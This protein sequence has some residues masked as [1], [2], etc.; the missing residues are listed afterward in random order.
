MERLR[1]ENEEM[2]EILLKSKN[3]FFPSVVLVHSLISDESQAKNRIDSR[4]LDL[5][6]LTEAVAERN[7]SL[8]NL[9]EKLEGEIQVL[10]D[11]IESLK[12]EV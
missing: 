4:T 10:E 12:V 7:I 6:K 3:G 8:S 11:S 2:S 1:K 5:N 9:K